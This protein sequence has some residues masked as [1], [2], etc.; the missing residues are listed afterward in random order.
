MLVRLAVLL[1]VI[2]VAGVSAPAARADTYEVW[3]IDQAN[4][5]DGGDRLYIYTPGDWTEPTETHYFWELAE[6]VGAGAGTRPHL[7]TWN[8]THSHGIL[9]NVASGHVYVIRA[10]DRTIVASI[11]VGEQAHGALASPDDKQILVS[12]QNGKK[13][14]RIHADFAAETFHHDPVEDLNLGALENPNQPDNAPICPMMYVGGGGKAYVTLRG[15]GLYVVDTMAAPMSVVREYS[16]DQIAPA[17]CGG[18]EHGGVVYVN[19]GSPADGNIYLFDPK[20]DDLIKTIPTSQYGSDAHGM[21]IVGD[22]YLWMGHRGNGD[23]IVILDTT[24]QEIVGQI[25]D[26]GAAPDLLDVSPGGDLVFATLRGPGALTGGPAA[27]GQT[28]GL[29]VLLVDQGGAAGKRVAFA[30]I[31]AQTAETK[32]DPH[33]IAVRRVS[34]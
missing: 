3:V 34:R 33:A 7:L 21:A 12:N 29:A 1:L 5:P 28:P 14:A 16:K 26:V 11:D 9:A 25:D 23:N 27:I 10:A 6:G 31:G 15:G 18:I 24:T 30:P 17:G 4:V 22:R 20:S 8:S 2:A 13:L 19:S 32:S